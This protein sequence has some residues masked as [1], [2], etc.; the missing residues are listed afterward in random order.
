MTFTINNP[1]K[2]EVRP[3]AVLFDLDNTL[4]PYRP[5]HEA[6]MRSIEDKAATK[7]GIEPDHFNSVFSRARSDIKNQLGN[8]ASS[9]SRLLYF[10]RTLEYLG[11]RSQVVLSLE[12]EQTYWRNFLSA[13]KLREG[14][15]E[16]L[17]LLARFSIP[18]VIITD[19]TSQIQFRK[20]V[21]LNLDQR[22]EYVVTSEESGADKPDGVG[23]KEARKKLSIE[24][25]PVW[26]I[27]DNYLGD[28]IGA[29]N[30]IGAATLGLRSELEEHAT[31]PQIDGIFDSFKEL[32]NYVRDRGWKES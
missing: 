16:F 6:G 29:K 28:L 19:L 25:E 20:L 26:M 8:A 17:D 7:L 30:A 31:D 3:A 13:I 12:F 2:L 21:F 15:T 22:F 23:F 11:L 27:G 24:L 32:G 5:A 10:Q 4:Y 9:H 14:V 18:K 1:G